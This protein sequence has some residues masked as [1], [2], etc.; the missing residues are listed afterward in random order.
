MTAP[1]AV[2]EAAKSSE[3]RNMVANDGK[4]TV[5]CCRIPRKDSDIK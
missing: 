2:N 4:I 5:R 3:H 1:K